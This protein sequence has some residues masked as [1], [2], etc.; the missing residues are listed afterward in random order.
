MEKVLTL[1]V[2]W[3][4]GPWTLGARVRHF[5]A[6]PL[7][8]DNSIRGEASTLTNVKASYRI[9]KSAEI[10]LEVFNLFNR[11]VNDIEY[12]YASRLP[13]EP[14]FADGVTANT[15]HFHP[16]L[17]RTARVGLKVAF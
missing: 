16:S 17:P 10:A 3:N 1:G 15:V 6:R 11:K 8:E 13:G 12:A 7:I 9:N 2:T 14:A 4:S 5:G